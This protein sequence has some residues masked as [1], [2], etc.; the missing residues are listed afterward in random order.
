MKYLYFVTCHHRSQLKDC[1]EIDSQELHPMPEP[2]LKL[3][4]YIKILSSFYCRCFIMDNLTKRTNDT[5]HTL[6][7]EKKA[8]WLEQYITSPYPG[9]LKPTF[10]LAVEIYKVCYSKQCNQQDTWRLIVVLKRHEWQ[11]TILSL[12]MTDNWAAV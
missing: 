2:C 11:R 3:F 6:N 12:S 4:M 1:V 9:P 10:T 7:N 5:I 8:C